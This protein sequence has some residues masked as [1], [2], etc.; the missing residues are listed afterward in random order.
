MTIS[1]KG[2]ALVKSFEGLRLAAYT[3]SAGIWTIGYGSTAN[4]KPGMVITQ[5]Q[6][7]DRLRADMAQAEHAVN[8]GVRIALNQSQF[9]ALCDFAFNVGIGNF[10]KSSLRE[11]LNEGNFVD[12][13]ALFSQWTKAG[14]KVLDGL[15]RRRAAEA[16]L[17]ASPTT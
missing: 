2:L 11:V 5:Q 15:V 4:V 9:D 7:D 14:G 13:P 1:D 12:A 17:F 16:A 8:I 6:A 10:L 3:D